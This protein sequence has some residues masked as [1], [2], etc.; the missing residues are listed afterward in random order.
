MLGSIILGSAIVGS[1][2]LEILPVEIEYGGGL[3]IPGSWMCGDTADGSIGTSFIGGDGIE[4]WTYVVEGS[5]S[6]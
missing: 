2:F 1:F 3:F 4:T 5:K 6:L